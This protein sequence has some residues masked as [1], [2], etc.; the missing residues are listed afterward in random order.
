MTAIPKIKTRRPSSK[1][2]RKLKRAPL[3][4]PAGS[5]RPVLIAATASGVESWVRAA[6]AEHALACV[7]YYCAATTVVGPGLVATPTAH[8]AQALKWNVRAAD[9]TLLIAPDGPLFGRARLAIDWCARYRKRWLVLTPA[10]FDAQTLIGWLRTQPPHTLHISG[11][12]AH[13]AGNLQALV[14]RVMTQLAGA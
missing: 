7:G 13:Q 2:R 4:I 10:S 8:P 6:S 9:A 12:L 11:P 1:A 5:P 14:E 3:I